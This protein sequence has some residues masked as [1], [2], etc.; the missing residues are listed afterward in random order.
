MNLIG[1]RVLPPRDANSFMKLYSE[2]GTSAY[3]KLQSSWRKEKSFSIKNSG[4]DSYFGMSA[5][6]L[7]QDTD[8]DVDEGATK[9]K[10]K[11]AFVKSLKTKKL[12]KRILGE[13][14]SLVV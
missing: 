11:S 14:I 12:N 7:N 10:I 3:D 5:A 6:A 4:Y 9:A 13:F 1:I 8:F 2:Y